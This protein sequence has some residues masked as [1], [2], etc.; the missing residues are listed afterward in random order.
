[1]NDYQLE[2]LVPVVAKLAE[3]YY[4]ATLGS[5]VQRRY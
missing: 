3:S 1:M 4:V 2:E 5:Y